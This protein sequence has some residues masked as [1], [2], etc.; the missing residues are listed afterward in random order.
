[1][2]Y[3]TKAYERL[4]AYD[5]K[6]S[7]QRIAIMEYLMSHPTHPSVDEIY[8]ELV[9]SIPTLSRTTVYNTLHL[10]AEQGAA[11]MLTIDDRNAHFDGFNEPHAHLLCRRCGTIHDLPMPR[12]MKSGVQMLE[13]HAVEEVHAYYKGVCKECLAAEKQQMA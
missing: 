12:G 2:K 7:V 6:P 5:I 3:N 13:G 4:L 11:L 10:F 9:V 8:K 1:M